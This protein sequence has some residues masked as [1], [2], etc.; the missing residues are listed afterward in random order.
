MS[1]C[2]PSPAALCRRNGKFRASSEKAKN[3]KKKVWREA[4]PLRPDLAPFLLLV[5]LRRFLAL[6]ELC[7]RWG[8]PTGEQFRAAACLRHLILTAKEMLNL[9]F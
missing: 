8:Q 4:W 6:A 7:F 9:R 5:K 1:V 2:L 3:S